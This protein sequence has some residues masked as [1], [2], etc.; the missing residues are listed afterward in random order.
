MPRRWTPLFGLLAFVATSAPG[1]GVI[2]EKSDIRFVTKQM[3]ANIEGRFRKWRANVVFKPQALAS[4]K[5]ELDI[6]LASIDLGSTEFEDEVRGAAWFDTAKF[7]VARFA[8][9]SIKDLGGGRYELAGQLTIKGIARDVAVPVTLRSDA[10]GNRIAEGRFTL[11][12]LD[13]KLGD[14]PWADTDMVANEV[15]VAVRMTLAPG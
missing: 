3:G 14:G 5:A 15:V 12:R 6:D 8:S 9:T 1:Q 11:K 10:A 7:P 2:V 4:S 13:Y